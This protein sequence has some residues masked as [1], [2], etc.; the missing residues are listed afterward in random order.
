MKKIIITTDFSESASLAAIYGIKF[1]QALGIKE[2]ILYHSFELPTVMLD[3]PISELEHEHEYEKSLENLE[4][5]KSLLEPYTDGDSNIEVVTNANPLLPGIERLAKA[6]DAD[7]VI[8]GGTGK[9]D[10]ARFFFGSNS[11]ILA[12]SCS[13]PL[14]IVPPEVEFTSIDNIVYACDLKS[15][16]ETTPVG[17]LKFLSER[18]DSKVLLLNVEVEGKHYNAD[19][20]PEQ[21]EL[22]KILNDIPAEFHYIKSSNLVEGILN[23][24]DE[25]NAK[26]VITVPKS[27]SFLEN[28]F[29]KSVTKKLADL[30]EVPLLV[31]RPPV[32]E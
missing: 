12:R 27:Y 30:S 21:K 14:L 11:K 31:L 7:L 29:H 4:K 19:I 24:A 15:A 1:G 5:L 26:L 9:G 13:L 3:I 23:F 8:A 25:E 18:L 28:I 6:K 32:K 20:I 10:I 16:L 17:S 22:H 2:Y